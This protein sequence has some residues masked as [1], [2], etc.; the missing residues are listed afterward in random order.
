MI[1][2]DVAPRSFVDR[3]QRSEG[4]SCTLNIKA[5]GTHVPNHTILTAVKKL[6]QIFAG[7]DLGTEGA[8]EP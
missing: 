6:R 3:H 7:L 2:L 4:A 1:L 5:V 8:R